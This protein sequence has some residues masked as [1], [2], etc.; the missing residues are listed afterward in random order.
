MK[1]NWNGELLQGMEELPMEESIG[2]IGGSESLWYWIGY[3]IGY[4][5]NSIR[6]DPGQSI[7]QKA[8]NAALT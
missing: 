2:I 6:N 5:A 3:G 8:M 4:I 7:G 1:K